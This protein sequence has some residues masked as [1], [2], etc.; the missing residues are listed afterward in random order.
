MRFLTRTFAF[1]AA[2]AFTMFTGCSNSAAISPKLSTPN[3]HVQ[4]RQPKAGYHGASYNACP[5]TGILVYV[6]DDN[7]NS[8]NIFAGDLAGQGPCGIISGSTSPQA[9]SVKSGNLYVPYGPP[10]PSVKAFH[11]G[12]TA[13]F[14]VY[15]DRTC[16]DEVPGDAT[17]SDDGFVFAS[18]Y[19]GRDCSS[20]SISVWKKSTGAFVG[21]YPNAD[22]HIIYTL[23]IQKDGTVYFVDDSP[24]LSVGKCVKGVCGSFT[25]TDAIFR[26]PGGIRSVGDEHIVLDDPGGS[27][28]GR[29]LT[30][31]PPSFGS[32][33]GSCSFG[34]HAPSGIDLNF[35]Q[36]HIFVVD[37]F[38]GVVSEFKYPAGGGHGH[39][40]VLSGTVSTSGGDPVGVAVDRPEPL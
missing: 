6:A 29:A 20:G 9:L 19:F 2:L 1:S 11:R 7:D 37:T 33:S 38:R 22:G 40:C 32:P 36:H 28:G 24:A 39:P 12:D 3:D 10:F 31:T 4:R 14:R 8:I 16:G 35:S 17:V 23:T 25:N 15:I 18:N 26:G 27:G 30:Y 34:G 21:N 13:P 5:S